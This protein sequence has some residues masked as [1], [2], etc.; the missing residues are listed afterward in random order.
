MNYSFFTQKAFIIFDCC[1]EFFKSVQLIDHQFQLYE[2]VI[3]KCKL[4]SIPLVPAACVIH[5]CLHLLN[6]V[7]CHYRLICNKHKSFPQNFG[8]MQLIKSQ[9]SSIGLAT[10]QLNAQKVYVDTDWKLSFV[11]D[12]VV[13]L[14]QLI[15]VQI[16]LKKLTNSK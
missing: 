4:L 13:C 8:Q 16:Q 2:N 14:L 9:K 15:R 1:I 6:C 3:V 10:E 12:R 5:L 7:Y 11:L